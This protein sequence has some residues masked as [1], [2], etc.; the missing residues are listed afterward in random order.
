MPPDVL[1]QQVLKLQRVVESLQ[2]KLALKEL[3]IDELTANGDGQLDIS[4]RNEMPE[5]IERMMD[6]LLLN[7]EYTQAFLNRIQ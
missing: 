2:K 3:L 4:E 1:Y 7:P 5:S 6:T